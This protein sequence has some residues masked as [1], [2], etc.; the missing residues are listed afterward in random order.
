MGMMCLWVLAEKEKVR[1]RVLR[2]AYRSVTHQ[3]TKQAASKKELV[4]CFVLFFRF[5]W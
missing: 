2:Y 1:D 4:F 5:S 3:R